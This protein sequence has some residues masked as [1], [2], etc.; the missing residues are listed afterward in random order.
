MLVLPNF[1]INQEIWNSF[2]S[3]IDLDQSNDE[4][5]ILEI[6]IE[7]L[8]QTGKFQFA[9][10]FNAEVIDGRIQQGFF[11]STQCDVGDTLEIIGK[12]IQLIEYDSILPFQ[13]NEPKV[14]QGVY[15]YSGYCQ[16]N[17][18]PNKALIQ[19]SFSNVF[20]RTTR[21]PK[22]LISGIVEIGGL[23][24]FLSGIGLILSYYHQS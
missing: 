5:F 7:N 8:P 11:K 9:N 18:N 16:P 23:V 10:T 2:Y 15:F 20:F 22:S 21:Y 12:F 6:Q 1:D 4:R 13:I 14:T 24:A 19:F 17:D 3:L